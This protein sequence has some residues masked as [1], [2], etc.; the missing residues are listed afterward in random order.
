MKPDD[1]QVEPHKPS[2]VLRPPMEIESKQTRK[3]IIIKRPKENNMDQ[4]SQEGST[5]LE[6]RKTKKITEL[7]SFEKHREVDSKYIGGEAARRKVREDKR[8]WEEEEKRRLAEIEREERA[9]RVY[10]E[11]RRMQE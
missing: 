2:I 9:R 3:K 6:S 8:W 1:V 5:G 11:Q 4:V 10:T 7:S